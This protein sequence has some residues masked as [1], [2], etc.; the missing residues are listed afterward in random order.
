MKQF[1]TLIFLL[2]CSSV[3]AAPKVITSHA[4]ALRGT[5][6]YQKNFTHFDYVNPN[7][8]KGGSLTMADIGTYDSFHRF[9]QRGVAAAGSGTLY[10]TLMVSSDDEIEVSY[11]LIAEKVEYPEDFTWMIFHLNAKAQFHDAHPI[12][13]EDVVFSFNT[14]FEKGVPQ[15]KQYYKDV[16]EVLALDKHRV[17]FSVRESN[18]EMLLSIASGLNILPK[19]YWESRD[20]SEPQTTPP[21]GS[22]A[23]RVKDFKIGQYVIYERV[24]DYWAADL[25]VKKG[26]SNFDIIRYDNYRDDTVALEAFKAGEFDLRQE[27]VSKYWATL[28]TGPN[29]DNKYIVREEIPHDIPQGMQALVFNI[30]K[31]IFSDPRVREAL[32]YAMDFEWMNKNLF[33]GQY[34]RTR[35]YFQNTQ[36]E[37]KG[38]PSSE[39]LKILEPLRGKIPDRVFTEEYQPPVTDGSGNIRK[40]TRAA[41]KLLKEAGWQVKNKVLSNAKT[42]KPFE[43]ELLI[44]SPTM[45]RIAIPVQ[46]NLKRMG[47]TMNIRQVDTTQFT[48]RMRSRD[49]DMISRGYSANAYPSTNL[50]IVWRSDYLDYTYN[51]AGVQ[52]PA[53]DALVDGIESAQQDTEALLHYGRAFDRVLQWNFFVIP[54]WHISKF[55]VASWD[56]FKRPAVRPKYSLG[57]DTWWVDP[58]KEKKLPKR[59]VSR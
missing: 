1:V 10:D 28:Y 34:R 50:K 7:A 54:E 8:S 44:Y 6:K 19:H 25:P 55:R 20:F 47:I 43:F 22:S 31:E 35:S 5:P 51:A 9:A 48:N 57:I 11:A 46:S 13:A 36:Y 39:E 2:W 16:T 30:K 45:E 26:Q 41:L 4:L 52:D 18:K 38:L 17:R 49:Y 15:F 58:D 21:L 59:N 32:V 23:Y 14:F 12:T 27:N 53:I 29:F 56:K 33:Y 40:Q 3:W 42:G 24:E 37:A